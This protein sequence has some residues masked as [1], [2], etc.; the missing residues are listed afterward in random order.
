MSKKHK[1]KKFQGSKSN[2]RSNH[3]H[4]YEKSIKII[5]WDRKAPYYT[6]EN[7]MFRVYWSSHCRICGKENPKADFFDDKDFKVSPYDQKPYSGFIG[8]Y[9]SYD[10]ICE[11]FPDVPIYR[12]HPTQWFGKDVRMR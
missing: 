11:K 2:K 12:N 10:D 8:H 9:M 5:F 1:K 6:P 7:D 4:D 3:K